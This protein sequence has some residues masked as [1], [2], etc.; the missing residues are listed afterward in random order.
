[1]V[2]SE[3]NW[4]F[5]SSDGRTYAYVTSPGQYSFSDPYV[6]G[7]RCEWSP[8]GGDE[9]D[10]YWSFSSSIAF[11]PITVEYAFPAVKVGATEEW[12]ESTTNS[13]AFAPN[14]VRFARLLIENHD[15]G[16]LVISYSDK[17]GDGDVAR[18]DVTGADVSVQKVLDACGK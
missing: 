5:K 18:F 6:L 7:V 10:V 4:T 3:G 13:A 8:S 16:K 14:G 1:M 9:I 11:E 15:S 2:E 12:W 17:Y